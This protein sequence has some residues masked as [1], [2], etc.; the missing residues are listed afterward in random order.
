MNPLQDGEGR[1][2]NSAAEARGYTHSSSGAAHDAGHL[3]QN[4]VGKRAPSFSK[5]AS[6]T[7][8][9]FRPYATDLSLQVW[10]PLHRWGKSLQQ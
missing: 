1:S 7:E 5:D 8:G 9:T 4:G 6:D 3:M 2:E 10:H